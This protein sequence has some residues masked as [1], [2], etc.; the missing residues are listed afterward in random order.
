MAVAL[1]RRRGGSATVGV[2]GGPAKPK[3]SAPRGFASRRNRPRRLTAKQRAVVERAEFELDHAA[4]GGDFDEFDAANPRVFDEFLRE[5]RRIARK[6]GR[7][8]A[9]YLFEWW[10][11]WHP[12]PIAEGRDPV[13]SNDLKPLYARAL[14]LADPSLAESVELKAIALE[15]REG[16]DCDYCRGQAK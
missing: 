8:T 2:V 15:R 1:S 9:A 13:L 4:G 10:R 12:F 6:G 3:S 7:P 5:A 14:V 16:C 11:V